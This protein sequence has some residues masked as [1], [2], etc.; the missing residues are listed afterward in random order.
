MILLRFIAQNK[1]KPSFSKKKMKNKFIWF[2]N[3]V[4]G[5]ETIYKYT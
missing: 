1:Q 2:Q 5:K 4:R 3:W